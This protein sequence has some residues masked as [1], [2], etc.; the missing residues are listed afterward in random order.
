M[1]KIDHSKGWMQ[2]FQFNIKIYTAWRPQFYFD[3]IK[4][5]IKKNL[6]ANEG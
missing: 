4:A 3:L 2:S 1:K 6:L 5:Y